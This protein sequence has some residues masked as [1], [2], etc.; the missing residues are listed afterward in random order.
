MSD[1]QKKNQKYMM[2]LITDSIISKA[3]YL[4][5]SIADPKLL[6]QNIE[7]L[8]LSDS[9]MG[10]ELRKLTGQNP[11]ITK[12]KYFP[13]APS[14]YSN[15]SDLSTTAAIM[16]LLY[17]NRNNSNSIEV[18]IAANIIADQVT[19]KLFGQGANRGKDGYMIREAC[20][21]AMQAFL[22]ENPGITAH[23]LI[24]SEN[25]PELIN[26][27]ATDIHKKTKYTT[28]GLVSGG[29]Y[30]PEGALTEEM[31]GKMAKQMHDSYK[32][33]KAE[34]EEIHALAQ[35]IGQNLF[36]GGEKGKRKEDTALIF[37]SLKD[38]I[39][40]MK[41]EHGGIEV[42]D[43]L[44]QKRTELIGKVDSGYFSVT[45]TGLT[46]E[47][48]QNTKYTTVGL[49]SGGIYLDPAR[50]KDP[51]FFSA[52]KEF[53]VGLTGNDI[54]KKEKSLQ[55]ETT[56]ERIK[57]MVG[58]VVNSSVEEHISNKSSS[59]TFAPPSRSSRTSELVK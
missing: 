14:S 46:K 10:Q 23:D 56:A 1:L 53:I 31:I 33:S 6:R 49:A 52:V 58:E 11:D 24:N 50:S 22:K 18:K 12:Y 47:Y 20:Q 43:I 2:D 34:L 27:L 5:E 16:T 55:P 37:E 21:T 32:F 8:Y 13:L 9:L 45:R 17:E 36:S 19:E 28:V 39:S 7:E 26:E 29:I 54:V 48:Y 59:Q 38:V 57:K 51:N 40:E 25:L 15:S 3:E 35:G 4:E 42:A 30:L 41:K 44:K